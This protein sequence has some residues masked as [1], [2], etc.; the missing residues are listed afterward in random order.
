ML[1]ERLQEFISSLICIK[2][3]DSDQS[4]TIQ[5]KS[6][7]SQN[8][9]ITFVLNQCC[10]N[11]VPELLKN[12]IIQL[13]D[14]FQTEHD[15]KVY[16]S[17]LCRALYDSIESMHFLRNRLYIN[18]IDKQKLRDN[19]WYN[20]YNCYDIVMNKELQQYLNITIDEYNKCLNTLLLNIRYDDEIILKQFDNIDQDQLILL[21]YSNED[22]ALRVLKMSI[23]FYFKKRI[24]TE[25]FNLNTDA[26]KIWSYLS[27]NTYDT[28]NDV[29]QYV[30]N[31]LI[32]YSDINYSYF[33]NNIVLT[34]YEKEII[35]QCFRNEIFKD[36]S[37][38]YV[39]FFNTCKKFGK[40]IDSE[41][42]QQLIKKIKTKTRYRQ[43]YNA[44]VHI[45]FT[46]SELNQLDAILLTYELRDK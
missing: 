5:T 22:M 41:I 4:A 39:E 40:F 28:S 29:R 44:K 34:D 18:E 36:I 43:I 3:K 26:Y 14:I 46:E 42:K 17:Y 20:A 2:Y 45:N 19:I 24:L 10:A 23:P 33:N 16:Q 35:Y 6:R 25:V 12:N 11:F 1:S 32:Q 15:K 38:T 27:Q 31:I 21:L 30:F 7:Y 37:S 8:K 9:E 13:Y